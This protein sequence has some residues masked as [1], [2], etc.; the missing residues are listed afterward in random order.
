MV[1]KWTKNGRFLACSGYPECSNAMSVDADGKPKQKQSQTTEHKCPKCG[2]PMIL[3]ES[4]YGTFLGCSGYPECKT[5]V[6]CDETGTPLP[7][8]K[9]D[10]VNV[11]CPECGKPMVAKKFRGRTF[12]GCSGYPECKTSMPVPNNITIDWPETKVEMTDIKCTKCGAPMVLRQSRRGPFLGCSA[13]P[14]CR[15]IMKVPKDE[16]KDETAKEDTKSANNETKQD[17]Q[18]EAPF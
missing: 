4:R 16:N 11:P 14:K 12:L 17:D 10:E 9:P 1:Y 2:K 7:K 5:T 6:P 13:F 18:S 8:V 3:R 15:N